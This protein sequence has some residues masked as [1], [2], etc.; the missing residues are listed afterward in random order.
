L[1]HV[2]RISGSKAHIWLNLGLYG[3]KLLFFYTLISTPFA[4]HAGVFSFITELLEG[5]QAAA[6][7]RHV[8]SQNLSVLQA[9]LGPSAT[10]PVGGGEI[11]IV[12]GSALVQESGVIGT[13]ADLAGESHSTQISLYVVRSG[14]SL[15]QIATMFGV[16]VNTIIWANN[17]KSAIHEGD[18][19]VILPISGVSHTVTKGDTIRSIAS[20][21]KADLGEVL[22]YNNLSIDDKLTVGSIL[23]IPDGEVRAAP[24]SSSKSASKLENGGGPLYK[25]YYSRPIEGGVRTQGL[26]GYNAVDLAAPIGT[27]IRA[28]A[29]GIVIISRSSGFNGGYGSYVVISHPNGTQTLYAHMNKVNVYQG[30]TLDKG[31]TLGTVGS[32]GKST[33]P[34]IHFE[35]R[36]AANPF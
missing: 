28:S 2:R 21:Y 35:I 24:V 3:V 10:S 1:T 33:G 11:A 29:Q 26:H 30:Q 36:G 16:S 32:T 8:T 12:D 25:G 22:S 9:N 23:I 6:D 27:T 5:K 15:S 31:E 19:L 20:K 4:A 18:E 17:I 13:Q 7:V 34:H 14:D